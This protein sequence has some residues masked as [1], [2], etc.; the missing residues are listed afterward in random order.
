MNDMQNG[1]L[2]ANDDY[3]PNLEGLATEHESAS[4]HISVTISTSGIPVKANIQN[5]QS[6]AN[7]TFD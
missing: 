7:V 3:W 4:L 2:Q 1:W 5:G 6:H